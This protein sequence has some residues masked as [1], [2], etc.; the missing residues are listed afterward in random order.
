MA[1]KIRPVLNAIDKSEKGKRVVIVPTS[2]K[3]ILVNNKKQFTFDR[4]YSATDYDHLLFDEC[5][6]PLVY[7]VL[8]GLNASVLAYGQTSSGKSR[9]LGTVSESSNLEN[10]GNIGLQIN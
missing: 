1:L 8:E 10:P 7:Q 2:N 9:A 3:A 5:V 4:V 6:E